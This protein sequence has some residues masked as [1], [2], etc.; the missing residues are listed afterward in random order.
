M[1]DLAYRDLRFKRLGAMRGGGFSPAVLFGAGDSGHWPDG[2]NPAAGRMFQAN[3]GGTLVSTAAQPVGLV[4]D[5]SG[6]GN[7][8]SQAT[9]LSRPT[10]ARWPKGGRRNFLAQSEGFET[11]AWVKYSKSGAP[12][13]IAAPGIAPPIG[14]GSSSKLHPTTSGDERF[15]YQGTAGAPAGPNVCS[16]FAKA[17]EK[18]VAY[19][20]NVGGQPS[21]L[22]YFNLAT[23]TAT[24]GS[25]GSAAFMTP[26]GDSWYRCGY[27]RPGVSSFIEI[28]VADAVGS[29]AVAANGNDGI[30]IAGAQYE[31]GSVVTPYQRVIISSFDVTEAG[32]AD[33]WRLSNDGGDSL[34]ATLPAGTYTVAWVNA[35]GVVTITPGVNVTTTLDTLRGADQADVLIINRPLTTAEATALTAYWERKFA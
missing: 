10:A 33:V 32:V 28:G 24:L 26:V 22:T 15:V 5:R 20:T 4:A 9:A 16:F 30:Y 21:L 7:D 12:T 14:V 6:N 19:I 18:S 13:A 3:T 2:Y 8:A 17:A 11:A 31:P 29:S 1:L 34:P 35:L 27:T 23:G 25:L